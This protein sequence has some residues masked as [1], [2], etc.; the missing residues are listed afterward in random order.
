MSEQRG[1]CLGCGLKLTN[2]K[3]HLLQLTPFALAILTALSTQSIEAAPEVIQIQAKCYQYSPREI[4]LKK[5]VPVVLQIT[6]LDKAH[7]FYV[8]DMNIDA[9]A[10]PGKPAQVSVTP[11]KSGI[12][13][14]SCDV[15]CGDGHDN[16]EGK[17]IVTD[18]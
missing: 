16:M 18:K 17:L 14:F 2:T 13:P 7:G 8:P 6:T 12:F 9:T 15:F 1:P 3:V 11:T 5:G 10:K 4:H